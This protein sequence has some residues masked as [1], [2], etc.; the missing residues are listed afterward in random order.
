[1]QYLLTLYQNALW[2]WYSSRRFN[3][4]KSRSQTGCHEI[5]PG[6][7]ISTFNSQ[8]VAEASLN[9]PEE[10]YREV[11]DEYVERRKCLIDG[12]NEFREFTLQ[13]LWAHFIQ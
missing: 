5:L 3:Y 12:L 13:F 9:A 1:M 6:T 4:Q 7:L 8:I 10:Y 2:M 11:Y